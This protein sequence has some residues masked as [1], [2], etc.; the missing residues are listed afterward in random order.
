MIGVAGAGAF[1]TALAVTQALENRQVILWTRSREKRDELRERRV[2][3]ES[4]PGVRL[5]DSIQPVSGAEAL[6][7]CESVLVAVPTQSLR[8]FISLHGAAL[9]GANLVLCCKGMETG[10]G[11][12]PSEIAAEAL[13]GAKC[14]V[15]TGPG[16][17]GEIA[18][19][20]PAALTLAS[21]PGGPSLQ[22]SLSA[23]TLR[24][25]LT[26]DVTGAQIGGALKNVYALACGFAIGVDLGESARAGLMTR[27]FAEMRRFARARGENPETL[28]GLCGIGDLALT[29][30]SEQSR[31]FM[32]GAR[33]GKAESING[34]TVEGVPTAHAVAAEAQRLGVDMP[35]AAAVC[36]VLQGSASIGEAMEELL[37]RK[38]KDEG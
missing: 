29:C 6:S 19:G 9:A 13:P 23:S 36:S 5:P 25:Y 4:L 22:E 33:F 18:R 7:K 8:E 30:A 16:F 21:G 1:G 10:T 38:L 14:S 35:I 26:G 12:L 20:K 32:H 17:A 11:L 15:L 34:E 24:L 28:A 2:N 37:S 3:P 31:N 27:G